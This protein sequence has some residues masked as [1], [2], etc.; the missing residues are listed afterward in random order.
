MASERVEIQFVADLSKAESGIESIDKS[1]DDVGKSAVTATGAFDRMASAISS[2]FVITAG[3]IANL[4]TTIGS[5]IGGALSGL[6][7]LIQEGAGLDDMAGSFQSLAEKAGAT[8]DVFLNQLSKSLGDTIP[9]I[10]LMKKANDLLLGGLKPDQIDLVA[11]A[12]RTFGEVTGTNAVAG[13]DA[14]GDS[15]LR[16]NDR[17][18]KTLG[19]VLDNDK[20]LSDYARSLGIEKDALT[21]NQK[22]EALRNETLKLL[23]ENTEKLGDVTEDSGDVIDQITTLIT[24]QVN[25]AIKAVGTNEDLKDA[26][27][28]LR[29]VIKEIDFAPIISGLSSLISVS[30]NAITELIKLG[31]AIGD[32]FDTRSEAVKGLDTQLENIDKFKKALGELSTAVGGAKTKEELE[33]LKGK[34]EELG[35]QLASDKAIADNYTAAF[36]GLNEG[37]NR[38]YKTLPNLNKEVE[39]VSNAQKKS[40]SETKSASKAADEAAKAAEKYKEMLKKQ[41]DELRNVVTK[42]DG[43]ADILEEI[44]SGNITTEQAGARLR[45][46]YQKTKTNITELNQAQEIYNGLIDAMNRGLSVSQTDL[47]AAALKVEELKNQLEEANQSGGFLDSLFNFEGNDTSQADIASRIGDVLATGISSALQSGDVEGALRGIATSMGSALGSAAGASLGPIGAAV[48]GALGEAIS[49]KII[50]DFSDFGKSSKGTGKG[51]KLAVDL[52]FPGLGSGLDAVFGDKLF[53]EAASTSLRK[54]IDRFFGEAFNAQRLSVIINGQ[55]QQITDLNFGGGL[56]GSAESEAAQFFSTLSSESQSAFGAVAQG[57]AQ[58]LG[59]GTEAAIGLAQVFSQN[60][61]GS[62]NNLQ[63]LV[64][65]TGLSFEQM[66]EQ[67]VEAFLNGELSALEAQTALQGI[68]KVAEKGIPDGIGLVKEAFDNIAAAGVKGGRTLV[69][70]LQDVGFEAKE[71]GDTTLEQ[72][73]QRLKNTAGVSAEEVDKVFGALNK[74]GI[75]TLDQL[76]NATANELIPALAE[77]E[78]QKFPFAEAAKDAKDYLDA[79]DRIPERKDVQINLKVNYPNSGDQRVVQDLASRGALGEGTATR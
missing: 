52:V 41:A 14:F 19:I 71:L 61:G 26:L 2:R 28:G 22:V 15:L 58:T 59:A 39:K 32:A 77:L 70:A 12:A 10:D 16:G 7:D 76:T 23:A 74:A 79:I 57:F 17:A 5:A 4:A 46:L 13:M 43:Y 54:S 48:G 47:A 21:E 30:A 63:L 65:A 49:N 33:G 72:V 40:T 24:D 55:L 18:L 67:V 45:D 6:P 60:L 42:S 3:D 9:K 69:D 20:A 36:V 68:Q 64:Q 37:A 11:K 73:M 53:G 75:S 27:T 29:D 31:A 56:F 1:L 51:I 78:G 66:S 34:F 44:R 35:N 25:E 38:L 50:K 8:S 62:L